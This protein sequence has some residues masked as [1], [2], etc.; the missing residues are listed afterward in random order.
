[1]KS[2]FQDDRH[3][4]QQIS[5]KA[6]HI[7]KDMKHRY[8]MGQSHAWNRDC[9][10][11]KISSFVI[12]LRIVKR[13]EAKILVPADCVSIFRASWPKKT[14]FSFI[15]LFEQLRRGPGNWKLITN[16]MISD[17]QKLPFVWE[18][19]LCKT[20]IV[21]VLKTER[22]VATME[23]CALYG[24]FISCFDRQFCCTMMYL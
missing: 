1:M 15:A 13:R 21:Y 6:D 16:G 9:F 11:Q 8:D 18:T 19:I 7:E 10:V 3:Y 22:T 2:S 20:P 12:T 24:L 14:T 5:R 23:T 17:C 4:Y